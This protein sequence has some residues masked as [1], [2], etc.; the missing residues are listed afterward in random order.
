MDPVTLATVICTA[1]ITTLTLI[2]NVWQSVKF[3]HFSLT[4]S[5]CC[6][7]ETESSENTTS[8]SKGQLRKIA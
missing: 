7:L 3:N 4:C 1:V 5:D 2:V 6:E 8:D